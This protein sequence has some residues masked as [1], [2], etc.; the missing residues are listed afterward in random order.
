MLIGKTDPGAPL[1]PVNMP[2]GKVNLH[3]LFFTLLERLS[4]ERELLHASAVFI[5]RHEHGGGSL[6]ERNGGEVEGVCGKGRR[7][8]RGGVRGASLT[9]FLFWSVL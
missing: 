4:R 6:E 8:L 1:V 9:L 5:W 7:V 3:A 2:F